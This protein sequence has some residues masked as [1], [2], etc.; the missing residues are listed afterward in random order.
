MA[1]KSVKIIAVC[2]VVVVAVGIIGFYLTGTF[3]DYVNDVVRD[4]VVVG[5]YIIYEETDT[6]SGD[7]ITESV[8]HEV[9]AISDDGSLTVKR[10]D[11]E[12]TTTESMTVE[13]LLGLMDPDV[14]LDEKG[15]E[16]IDTPF[17][18]RKCRVLE[19]EFLGSTM[20]EFVGVDNGVFYYGEIPGSTITLKDTSLFSVIDDGRDGDTVDLEFRG[21]LVVGDYYILDVDVTWVPERPGSLT[22]ETG[23]YRVVSIDPVGKVDY[24]KYTVRD[25][26][27]M[28]SDWSGTAQDFYSNIHP[29]AE[30]LADFT[31]EKKEVLTTPWGDVECDVMLY[32]AYSPFLEGNMDQRVYLDPSSGVCLKIVSSVEDGSDYDSFEQ[33]VTLMESSQIT[34]SSRPQS[35]ESQPVQVGKLTFRDDLRAGDYYLVAEKREWDFGNRLENHGSNIRYDV[36]WVQD[37]VVSYTIDHGQEYATGSVDSFLMDLRPA[38]DDLVLV[39]TIQMS[40]SW[41]KRTVDV[42][43]SYEWASNLSKPLKMHVYVDSQLGV[44]YMMRAEATDVWDSTYE[45]NVERIEFGWQLIDT[46]LLNKG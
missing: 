13:R 5:D 38:L 46:N 4:E 31:Y 8:K 11:G 15:T 37:G 22:D 30:T 41:G 40:T 39:D 6:Y 14:G 17:G 21:A 33:V 28:E 45:T 20:R 10:T 2:A 36:D 16:V 25:D 12:G 18:K 3:D 1:S 29:S 42:Y 7:R 43:T 44:C 27:P 34:K 23:T 24:V 32:S 26:G 35:G 9:T 19:T